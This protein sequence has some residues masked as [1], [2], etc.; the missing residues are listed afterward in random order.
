MKKLLALSLTIIAASVLMLGSGCATSPNAP[1][2]IAPSALLSG[3]FNIGTVN[4]ALALEAAS[5]CQQPGT[6]DATGTGVNFHWAK[7]V[8][9]GYVF[10]AIVP[11]TP[12]REALMRADWLA[13]QIY[14]IHNDK[15]SVDVV[16]SGLGVFVAIHMAALPSTLNPTNPLYTNTVV[17]PP[18]FVITT[19][20]VPGLTNTVVTQVIK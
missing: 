18:S 5:F 14:A 13:S 4:P 7:N 2:N 1:I 3:N 8:P 16:A 17:T 19:N 15:N 20:A 9:P 12:D 10:Q 11:A 6:I